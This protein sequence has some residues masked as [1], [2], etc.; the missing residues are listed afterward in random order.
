MR[1]RR[2]LA[3]LPALTFTPVFAQT[4]NI[5]PNHTHPSFETSHMGISVW[6]GLFTKTGGTIVLD[7]KAKTGTVEVNIDPASINIGNAQLN[8]HLRGAD[9][10]DVAKF[11]KI[12]YTGRI[13]EW[14]GDAP[15]AVEGELSLH[16]VTHPLKLVINTFKC[17]PH[18]MLKR[19]VCGADAAGSFKRS[20]FGIRYGLPLHGD[21]MKLAIQVEA[22]KAD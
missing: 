17:I 10:F 5:D 1:I 18:P 22:I 4:Y 21:E 3:V 16:G 9:F 13:S 19:E 11:P 20:E 15:A 12:T 7:R 2:L 8:E 6:R 14:K